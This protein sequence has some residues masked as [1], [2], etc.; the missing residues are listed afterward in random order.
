M[1]RR[2]LSEWEAELE[3]AAASDGRSWH[4]CHSQ[5]QAGGRTN[6]VFVASRWPIVSV[7]NPHSFEVP[8]HARVIAVT[9]DVDGHALRVINTHVPD[10]SSHGWR[11]VEHFEGLYR[12]L[13]RMHTPGSPPGILCGDFNEPRLV[14]DDGYL[15]TWAQ[16][17]SG[18][19]RP[20]RGQRWDAGVR[21]VLIGLRA[22]DLADVYVDHPAETASPDDCSWVARNGTG[23][24][25]DHIFAARA[26]RPKE[27]GYVHSWRKQGLSDHSAVWATFD[28]PRATEASGRALGRHER[29]PDPGAC[30]S[31]LRPEGAQT[32]SQPRTV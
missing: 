23:R 14:R 17:P 15:L 30:G 10:G 13:S 7:E 9:L 24:R 3:T 19:L 8:F 20:A 21:S 22:F 5:E 16:R 26:L 28:W 1:R 27:C 6:F 32:R 29:A 2:R 4:I 11:K 12:Y 31:R 18:E 25:Y